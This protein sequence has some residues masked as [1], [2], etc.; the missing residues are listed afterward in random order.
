M[1]KAAAKLTACV[2]IM[3]RGRTREA[4]LSSSA[5][6]QD[7]SAE[8]REEMGVRIPTSTAS[9]VLPQPLLSW[10]EV[11]TKVASL[12]GE[13]VQNTT[14]YAMNPS[15]KTISILASNTGRCLTRT[16]LKKMAAALKAIAISAA[17]QPGSK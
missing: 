17:C 12:R 5:R 8:V 7:E 2:A 15:A 10:I 3:A 11:K 14:T 1:T 4:S 16:V 6:W 13:R 9:P